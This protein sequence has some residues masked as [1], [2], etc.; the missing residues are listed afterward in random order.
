MSWKHLDKQ[1]QFFSTRLTSE[2]KLT[3]EMASRLAT[4]IASDVRFLSLEQKEEIK[5]ASPVPLS[6]RLDEL[7]AFQDWMD[8]ARTNKNK[9]Y[10]IRAQ[11]ITQ[12][13]VCF[14]YLPESCFRILAKICANG[15]ATK[16]CAQFLSNN[17]VRAFRNAVAHAN[18]T[19]R[20]DF[21]A[22]VYWA[23]KG[24]DPNEPLERFEV[25]QEDLL[26]WQALSRCVAYA[27]YSNL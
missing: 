23:R 13:Y 18:W 5:A 3:S 27:A 22:L 10:I 1:M 16:K 11:V 8:Y 15:S 17:P 4:T 2:V 26:F 9:P 20:P 21:N 25:K 7:Q 14:V 24:S 19:Y 12:S 6:D